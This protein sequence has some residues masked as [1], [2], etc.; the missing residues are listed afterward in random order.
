MNKNLNFLFVALVIIVTGII[1]F[2]FSLPGQT[3]KDEAQTKEANNNLNNVSGITANINSSAA[4]KNQS[5]NSA[6]GVVN[7]NQN[8][9]EKITLPDGL[10]ITDEVLGVGAE[11]T[12]G[13][14]VSV[15]YVGTLTNG[16]KF[17]SS[18]DRNQPFSFVLGIGKVIAGWDEGV[19]GM[20]V[21]GKR[22][23]AIPPA[24]AYGNQSVGNGLIPPNS[25]LIFEV[26]LLGVQAQ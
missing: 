16:K 2:V 11:A 3:V 12:A 5:Q 15:N 10:Q 20:K 19:A 17:D 18:Y 22:K 24:L 21:G 9:M 4:D 26:E 7:N 23:L 14:I 13:N 25:T 6:G 8:K 1:F